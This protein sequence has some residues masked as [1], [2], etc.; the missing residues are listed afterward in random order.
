[1][2]RITLVVAVLALQLAFAKDRS[3]QD[4]IYLGENSSQDGAVAMPIGNMSVAVP[5]HSNN[6]YFSL[7]GLVYCLNFPSRLS[8]RIPNLTVNGHTKI[9][10]DGRR[11]YIVDDD[12]KNWTLT[13]IGKVAPKIAE[14]PSS[15][16][17]AS[18][19]PAKPQ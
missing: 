3:W 12:G 1:M 10:L 2:K 8:G 17:A 14:P 4:A 9:A 15:T 11:A 18:A 7:N 19:V 5:L 16:A 13:I 6:L